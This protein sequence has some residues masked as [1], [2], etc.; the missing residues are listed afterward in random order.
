ML[1]LTTLLLIILCLAA[2]LPAQNDEMKF[3]RISLEQGLSQCSITAIIQDHHGFLW[4]GT[5][6]GVN[7]YDGYGFTIFKYDP[8]N[9]NALS[10][11][12]VTAVYEDRTGTIWVGTHAG[13]LNKYNPGNKTFIHYQHDP[14]NP[15]SL[16]HDFVTAICEDRFGALWVGTRGGGLN[17][18]DREK[19]VFHRYFPNMADKAALNDSFVTAIY[20]DRS[21]TL[22]IGTASGG[23]N[24]F[25]REKKTFARYC[26]DPEQAGSLSDDY[27]TAICE[28]DDEPGSALWIGT[29]ECGLNKLDRRTGRFSHYMA[30]MADPGSLSSNF[31]LKL[32]KTLEHGNSVLWIGTANGLDK[33]N[34]RSNTFTHV[35]N[36]P[37]DPHSLSNNSVSAIC[38]DRS[39]ILWVGTDGGGL[40]KFD[41]KKKRFNHFA[42]DPN[43]KNSLGENSIWALC[44][45]PGA[46]GRILWIGAGNSGLVKFDRQANTFKHYRHDPANLNSLSHN[47]VFEIYADP[48][49]A[50]KVLWIGTD[51]GLNKFDTRQ[52][53]FTLYRRDP[54]NP[55]SL[56]A[57][58][59]RVIY[60]DRFGMLWIGTTNGLNMLDRK[61][62]RFTRYV[63]DPDNPRSLG[64]NRALC[65]GEDRWGRLWIGTRNGLYLFDRESETF[66]PYRHDPMNSNSL[67]RD[68]VDA[69]FS[70]STGNLWLGTY[71]GG[72]NRL[73]SP[74]PG[75]AAS[76][77]GN[78]KAVFTCFTEKNGLANNVVY[79]ILP[80]ARGNL[81]LSTNRGLSKFN[82]RTESFKNYD[83]TDG[84]Q[85][86]EFN[87][88]AYHRGPRGEMFFGGNNGFNCF[89]PENIKDNEHAPAVVI[90]AFKK[91]DR[92]VEFDR[93][94][95]DL[96]AM[97][98]SADD[99]FI[100]FEFVALDYTNPQNN[101]YAYQLDG[102]DETWIYCGARRYAS[103][104][105]LNPGKYV[106]RVKASNND[107]VWN[108]VGYAVTITI[109]PPFWQTW[110]FA[111]LSTGSLIGAAVVFY[112]YK[113]KYQIRRAL[114]MEGVRTLENER[115]RKQ[116]ADDFHDEL[117]Q[118]LTNMTL[119]AE[120][121]KRNLNG[122]AKEN[123]NYLDKIR[124]TSATLS[125]GVRNFI[126]A[127]DPEQDSLYDLAIYLKDSGDEIF[128]KTGI[129]FRARGILPELERVKLPMN[130]RRHLTLIFKE[131]MNNILKH[132]ACKNVTLEIALKHDSL[133]IALSDDGKGFKGNGQNGANG[134]SGRGL[135]SMSNRAAKLQ[136]E[137]RVITYLGRGTT[138]Q[139]RGKM[140][141]VGYGHSVASR[142]I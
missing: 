136:G 96:D 107:G 105:N 112:K 63:H 117:G 17:E 118:K 51:N 86:Y 72:L 31:I 2:A 61:T 66:T 24:R 119:F 59:I 13:G 87:A 14:Q 88:S 113:M 124:E 125:I 129:H 115:V 47:A 83:P 28:T 6:D 32:Y 1:R 9:P 62:G 110:W 97:I 50:G 71:G 5:E 52:E 122:I 127:L 35:R 19:N 139:F 8:Y 94:I 69:I 25:E 92:V 73:T 75:S 58:G 45:D 65:F 111:L 54:N 89:F 98:L 74:A 116:V 141:Q 39:G 60:K 18:F 33:L 134:E 128:D 67:S 85:S 106:F 93:D 42:N 130:W 22:W 49:D 123:A 78:A 29:L 56:S 23:L 43:K 91:F 55:H 101:K 102:F 15:A 81:W 103:Y 131:G 68:M 142:L 44:E 26:H 95:A 77:S 80:D 3:E 137:I 70:D 114:E 121:L 53:R 109:K 46:A 64:N 4:F 140:P 34:I 100:A 40:N 38:Q 108:E 90:T 20:E 138:I 16:S 135:N 82:P 132:A 133:I 21:G 99:D 48:D 10:D 57:N 30:N 76:E 36:A 126:W 120:I 104:T 7:R 41:R 11:N 27:V 12:L 37:N 79:S 84:L